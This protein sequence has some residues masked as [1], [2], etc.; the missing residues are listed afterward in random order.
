MDLRTEIQLVVCS[1]D[2]SNNVSICYQTQCGRAG[3]SII[4]LCGVLA[5]PWPVIISSPAAAAEI[6]TLHPNPL[7]NY[8]LVTSSQLLNN[9]LSSSD[10]PNIGRDYSEVLCFPY[11]VAGIYHSIEG[12][13][14]FI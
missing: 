10:H 4:S 9:F 5:G 3:A 11:Q 1:T 6:I 14:Y 7:C 12:Q 8:A 13:D 2:D